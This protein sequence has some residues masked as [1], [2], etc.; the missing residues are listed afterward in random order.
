[1]CIRDSDLTGTFPF[2]LVLDENV[3]ETLDSCGCPPLGEFDPELK[4]AWFIPRE[5]I[6]KKTKN[7]KDYWIVKVID[8]TSSVASI[9]CWGVKK[10]VDNL[11]INRPYMAKLDYSEQWGFSTRSLRHNFR[12]LS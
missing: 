1:M 8:S 6:E 2:E 5:I 11:F 4:I 3:L 7:G 9:K 10:G 12:I